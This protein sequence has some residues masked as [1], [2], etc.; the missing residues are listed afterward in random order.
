MDRVRELAIPTTRQGL[1]S[2]KVSRAKSLLRSGYTQAEVAEI[3][4]VS[5]TTLEK[6]GVL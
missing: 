4:G 3:I 1:S 5:V 2:A 6:N